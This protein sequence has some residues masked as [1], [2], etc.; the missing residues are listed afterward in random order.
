MKKVIT[1]AAIVASSVSPAMAQMSDEWHHPATEVAS[2]SNPSPPLDFISK[3]AT[4]C[5]TIGEV[6]PE[7]CSGLGTLKL[8]KEQ[9]VFV[10]KRVSPDG[11]TGAK[12]ACVSSANFGRCY[13]LSSDYLTGETPVFGPMHHGRAICSRCRR[14]R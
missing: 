3:D 11:E 8:E 5:P 6:T 12:F 14:V 10:H 13:W 2:K 7:G 9:P 4:A 1:A